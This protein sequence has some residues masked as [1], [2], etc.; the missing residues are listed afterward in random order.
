MCVFLHAPWSW[1]LFQWSQSIASTTALRRW[2][3][4]CVNFIGPRD[5]YIAGD[6]F[7]LSLPVRVFLEETSIWI[8][9]L[10]KED[11]P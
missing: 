3:I 10:G 4:S 6:S 9:R 11:P 8:T 7:F 2:L 1:K 5:A